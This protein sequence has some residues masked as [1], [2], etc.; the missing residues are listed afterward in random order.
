M[1][2]FTEE[3]YRIKIIKIFIRRGFPKDSLELNKKI[4]I[5]HK[6]KNSFIPDLVIKKKDGTCFVVIEVKKNSKNIEEAFSF[7][8]SPAVKILDAKYG[9]YYDGSEKSFVFENG[10]EKIKKN[11]NS[12]KSLKKIFPKS[13]D[14]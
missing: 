7:Q 1:P 2:N 10:K 14:F 5:G 12:L 11:F 8:L 4:R 3:Y 13:K 6:G 9:I